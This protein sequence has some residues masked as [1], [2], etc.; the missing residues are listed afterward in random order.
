MRR[1]LKRCAPWVG[2]PLAPVVPTPQATAFGAVAD[3]LLDNAARGWL[4]C[5]ALPGGGGAA[6]MLL[7]CTVFAFTHAVRRKRRG[8]GGVHGRWHGRHRQQHA[9]SGVRNQTRRDAWLAFS[10]LQAAVCASHTCPQLILCTSPCLHPILAPGKRCQME[11][12]VFCVR[13]AMG[14][15]SDGQRLSHA[16]GRCRGRGAYG[17]A[18]VGVGHPV[19]WTGRCVPCSCVPAR[20]W[21]CRV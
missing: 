7:E 2:R 11:A 6:L 9:Q 16:A 18:V 15:R 13:A 14:A 10:L 20:C 17:R 8:G 5:G 12:G 21:S 3:V 19:R 4:W 1:S